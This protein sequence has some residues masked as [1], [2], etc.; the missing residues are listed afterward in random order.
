MGM[1]LMG[2]LRDLGFGITLPAAL[3]SINF[4][5]KCAIN[6]FDLKVSFLHYQV[7]AVWLVDDLLFFFVKKKKKVSVRNFLLLMFY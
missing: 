4:R 1:R 2:H 5:M 6:E 7:S 3:S